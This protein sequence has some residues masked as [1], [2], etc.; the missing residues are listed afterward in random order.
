MGTRIRNPDSLEEAVRFEDEQYRFTG[1]RPTVKSGT[2]RG[3]LPDILAT[4]HSEHRYIHSLLDTLEGQADKLTPGRIPDYQ[5]LLDVVDYL[6]HYPDRYHH[7][8]E[9][10]LFGGLLKKDSAFGKHV[11]RLEREH[12]VLRTYNDQLFRELRGITAGRQVEQQR[13]QRSLLRYVKGYREHMEFESREIFSR[14]SGS[15][16]K[17]DLQKLSA[18]TRY[19]DDPIFGDGVQKR[20]RRLARNLG[21]RVGDLGIDLATAEMTLLEH[22]MERLDRGIQSIDEWQRRRHATAGPDRLRGRGPSWHARVLNGFTRV[23]MKPLLG[24]GSI[25]TGRSVMA[26]LDA[27]QEALLPDDIS[28]RE[29]TRAGYAG[30]WVKIGNRRPKRTVLYFPGGGFVLRTATQHRAFVARICREAHARSLIVHYRL[31][32]EVPF[33]GG[34]E[35]C[36]AAYHDLLAQGV[37]PENITI[38]GDSAGGGLVLSTLLA[39]RDEGTPMPANAIVLSPLADV[40]NSGDSRVIN[41]YRDPV[42]PARRISDLQNLYIGDAPPEDRF[43]SPVFAD[44]DGLPPILGQV[45]ST[46]ILLDDTLRS[47]QRAGDAG[48]PF[49]LEVWRDMPHVHSFFEILP[50]AQIA[51]ERMAEF[52]CSG[53]L[54]PLPEDLGW[55]DWTV[56]AHLRT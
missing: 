26:R 35:D 3:A 4:L 16:S 33:P 5:L 55:S 39:L 15:L 54:G 49:Y 43:A 30:E 38:A 8:R 37:K 53:E 56:F 7:P 11:K 32:P 20:F 9:D 42:L 25:E 24:F 23:T 31:A 41:K 51:V 13:L 1:G 48:V 12:R 47:A 18:R 45:G 27:R 10:L 40:T 19:I 36:L 50:E 14:A 34:L 29:V 46:E 52:I 28:A 2:P 6:T 44:F 22:A 17:P 21:S